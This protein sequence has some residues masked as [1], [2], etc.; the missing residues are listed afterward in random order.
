M[1]MTEADKRYFNQVD[2][3]TKE[4]IAIFREL[5]DFCDSNIIPIL[6]KKFVRLAEIEEFTGLL[7]EELLDEN[8]Y[9]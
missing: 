9:D 4:Y 8:N 5:H 7:E 3:M 2:E 6:K 1:T